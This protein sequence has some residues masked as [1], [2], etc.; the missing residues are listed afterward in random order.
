[1]ARELTPSEIEELFG[2]YALDALDADERAEVDAYLDRSVAARTEVAGLQEV[3]AMLAHSGG[4]APDGL[5]DRIEHALAAEPPR[6]VLPLDRARIERARHRSMGGKV[7]LAIAGASAAAA[8][9][10]AVVVSSQMSAQEDRL[11]RVASSVA[12]DGVRRA[13]MGALADPRGRTVRLVAPDGAG[14]ATVVSMPDGGGFLL[15]HDVARLA[16]GRT[17]QLW[18]MTGDAGTPGLVSAGVLGRDL[19]VTAFHAPASAHG[20]VVTDEAEPGAVTATNHVMLS[21]EFA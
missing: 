19:D 12:H 9:V 15:A 18:A 5:W 2:A 20:F 3:A 16:P 6:L 10:T 13:A 7:V 8:L 4:A 14:S 11:D 17:Y 21:G 1:M